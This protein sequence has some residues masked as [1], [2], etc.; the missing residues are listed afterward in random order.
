[1]IVKLIFTTHAKGEQVK[2]GT[3]QMLHNCLVLHIKSSEL[4]PIYSFVFLF[5]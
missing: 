4:T 2:S 5:F 3:M 1:M